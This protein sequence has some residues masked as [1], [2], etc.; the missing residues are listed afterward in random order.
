MTSVE[1]KVIN[2]E[3][4]WTHL[5]SSASGYYNFLP[6]YFTSFLPYF[7]VTYADNNMVLFNA[8]ALLL[9]FA[10]EE[11]EE[12]FPGSTI[13]PAVLPGTESHGGEKKC[14][15]RK[16]YLGECVNAVTYVNPGT[17]CPSDQCLTDDDC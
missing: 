2:E 14:R 1:V 3:T 11:E 12:G 9:A 5:G 17:P 6:A 15:W 13:P 10:T 7:L 8:D 16:C 4:S